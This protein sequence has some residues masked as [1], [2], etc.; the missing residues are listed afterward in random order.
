MKK[1]SLFLL[2]LLLIMTG[3][4]GASAQEAYCDLEKNVASNGSLHSVTATFYYDEQRSIR[5]ETVDVPDN[6][7][8]VN[9]PVAD[10]VNVRFDPSF[11]DYRPHSTAN[12]F[13]WLQARV[14][15]SFEGWQYFNTSEVTNMS[16][17]FYAL[18]KYEDGD[19]VKT[20]AVENL[21]LSFFDTSNVKDMCS[22]F[23]YVSGVDNLDISS[24]T[25]NQGTL[26]DGMMGQS[27]FQ[28]ITIPA[29]ADNLSET[30]FIYTPSFG[31]CTLICPAGFT[32][33]GISQ[34]DGWFS[35]KGGNF[36]YPSNSG[37]EAYY[38][39]VA[40]DNAGEGY[41]TDTD[42]TFYYDN[43]RNTREEDTFLLP[44]NGG[45]LSIT[46]GETIE[47]VFTSSFADYRPT[48]TSHWFEDLSGLVVSFSGME[49]LNTSIVT[50][51][52]YMFYRMTGSWGLEL[53]LSHF[54]TSNVT[55]MSYMF[56]EII[57]DSENGSKI[58]LSAFDFKSS[59]NT[60]GLLQN[61][62]FK[63]LV[64][65]VSANHLDSDAFFGV[66]SH[67][68]I[69][70]Y[71]P[72]IFTP[73]SI[74]QYDGYFFWKGG[75]FKLPEAYAVL[76]YS[77]NGDYRLKFYYDGNRESWS[78]ILDGK[79]KIYSM[80]T[81]SNYPDWCADA[82]AIGTNKVFF[83]ESFANY[84]PKTCSHWFQ[85][86]PIREIYGLEY[87]NTSEV[88]S[89]F[90]MFMYCSEI[91]DLDLSHFDT[92]N[93]RD[94]HQMF[95]K[96]SNLKSLN[97][98]SF[99]WGTDIDTSWLLN[100]CSSL[101]K[102][103]ISSS[104]A[105]ISSSACEG[106][107][108]SENPCTLIYP[109]DYI[110]ASLAEDNAFKWK[111]GWFIG[112][113]KEP[114]AV[115]SPDM[116]TLAFYS[117]KYRE[118]REEKTYGMNDKAADGSDKPIWI[119]DQVYGQYVREVIETVTF[120]ISLQYTSLINSCRSMF[121][122]MTNLT[123]IEG[124]EF[125]NT[126]NVRNMSNMFY[127]CSRLENIDFGNYQFT[128]GNVINMSSMFYGCSS[129]KELN[130]SCFYTSNVTDMNNMFAGCSGLTSL[131]LSNFDT[132]NVIDMSGM[133]LECSG[134]TSLDLSHFDTSNVYM[135][136]YMF[137][138]CSGLTSLDLSNFVFSN[139][140][141]CNSLLWNTNLKRLSIPSTAIGLD[142]DAFDEVG[143]ANSPCE[144]DYP[145]TIGSDI[146]NSAIGY[147]NGKKL[148][149]YKYGYFTD[150]TKA[151]ATVQS[152]SLAFHYDTSF[153]DFYHQG[154]EVH[155][156]NTGD[157]APT[158]QSSSQSVTNVTFDA[159]FAN[160][161]PTSCYQW[162]KDMAI[163]SIDLTNLNTG[164]V[165]SFY[166]M[167]SG[168]TQLKELDLSGITIS[169]VTIP[170]P[171]G[172]G[173]SMRP[174][175]TENMLKNCLAL[176]SLTVNDMANQS[177][178]ITAC[179]GVGT[180]TNPCYLDY[181]EDMTLDKTSETDTYFVWKG[182]YFTDNDGLPGD[183][184]GDGAISVADVMI[185]VC[186]V[187]GMEMSSFNQKNADVNKDGQIT[188]TDVMLIVKMVASG[189]SS[190]P[191]NANHSMSDAMEVTAKGSELTLH[192][193]GTGSYTASQMMLTLPEGCRL[194]SAQMVSSRDNGHSVRIN[195]LGNG[196]Y[197]VVIYGAY[198]M[199]FRNSCTDLVRLQVAGNHGGDVS[200]SD[201]QVV[202]AQ[203]NTFLLSDVSGI[204]TGIESISTDT[205]N[206]GDWYTTQ[207][208]RVSTPTRGIYIRN[209]RKV[210][211]TKK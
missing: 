14:K 8:K 53:D 111:S 125:L 134:L 48:N 104:A 90:Q 200:L 29:T 96:C 41:I 95:Y 157:V 18:G 169:W 91:E 163:T 152:T 162:F 127:G 193:T 83:D 146:L 195:E 207:G 199:P 107:G 170:D 198:G 112:I 154:T 44:E 61:S 155:W 25:I 203:T 106:V 17:M 72:E 68:P 11:A 156:L 178:D 58:D 115:L 143:S 173:F 165:S 9:I 13:F 10:Y 60:K 204:A 51:M 180:D 73:Q 210:V 185:T 74:T 123:T 109:E 50:D 118:Y 129:L 35:W 206:D 1:T 181:P 159:S 108:T 137:H 85:G 31:Y 150:V 132:S 138:S 27:E 114:Y 136:N 121:E 177:F 184:N 144:L 75:Y 179:V 77:L 20:C 87:L 47:I 168:C 66:G 28:R 124:L 139:L 92:S 117:D 126:S 39:V 171:N 99:T 148:Y 211:V 100:D 82:A 130:M 208:Q 131:N 119:T 161:R 84:R 81:G 194:E 113:P 22:M 63:Y 40:K 145:L 4:L 94:F 166:E 59:V 89:M 46:D 122:G 65:P 140:R 167:F 57:G 19:E 32:P 2:T 76:D 103:I 7:G 71:Y 70:L 52:S 205:T 102:L 182:G 201:I 101:S 158:W 80:N 45:K 141:D 202:D 62:N 36:T 15:V 23:N 6:Y 133:F 55:N 149:H 186:N 135:M 24:F 116:K 110:P 3:A 105:Y 191:R 120:D 38:T 69:T 183:A 33:Q 192:L 12:W 197:C 97:L 67:D 190:A 56:S 174:A 86:I 37:K 88:T 153:T 142:S 54:D 175:S 79:Y 187:R 30:A 26:T 151:Y 160:A 49:N 188:I 64:V 209:G 189:S 16:N 43:L 128:T 172:F 176:R 78:G 42:V 196:Q 21:N 98:K 164:S 5:N 147:Y 34:Y 93:V